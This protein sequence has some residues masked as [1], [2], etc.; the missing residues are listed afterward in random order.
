MRDILPKKAAYKLYNCF[1]EVVEARVLFL[2]TAWLTWSGL[3]QE[4]VGIKKPK[5]Q[6]F[7]QCY[8]YL[9]SA[10]PYLATSRR[11]LT[12]FRASPLMRSIL[13]IMLIHGTLKFT[14][15]DIADITPLEN[16]V[17]LNLEILQGMNT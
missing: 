2:S 4:W 6:P 14:I 7:T 1:V 12:P 10:R 3:H 8:V 15:A 5:I 9:C 17:S 13:D 11:P 16:T